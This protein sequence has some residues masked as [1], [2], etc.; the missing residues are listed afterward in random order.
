MH[1]IKIFTK[2]YTHSYMYTYISLLRLGVSIGLCINC[3]SE[4]VGSNRYAG[5]VSARQQKTNQPF[6]LSLSL[7]RSPVKG[8]AQIKGVPQDLD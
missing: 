4:E 5:K 8:M 1:Q 2:E 6:L 7:H 3:N